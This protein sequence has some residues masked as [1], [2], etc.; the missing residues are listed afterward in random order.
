MKVLCLGNNTSDTDI[1]T[2]KLANEDASK[3]HGLLSEL[4]API[5]KI[6]QNGWYH[7]SVYDVAY[8]RLVELASGFDSV[9]MLDQPKEQYSHPDAFYKTISLIESLPN[10]KFLN[11]GYANGIVFFKN[12]VK[13]NKSFCIF[14]FIELLTNQR[15]DGYTT[16]C[17]RSMTPVAHLSEITD[18]KTNTNYKEIRDKMINGVLVPEHCS[19]C[20]RLEDKNILSAR[21][22]E[23]VEWANR[24][25]LTSLEDLVKLTHPTYYEI[26]PGNVCNL[27]CRM[28]G[29]TSSHLL[30]REYKK[31][32]LISEISPKERSNFSIIDFTNLKK[33]YV[34]GGEPT[35]MPEFYE[36]L[37]RCIQQKQTDFEFLI[38][39][40]A[41]KFNNRLKK[42]LK[43]FSNLQ[44]IV[45]VDGLESLNHY[46][47]W[48]SQWDKI[49]ENMHYLRKNNCIGGVNITISIY[50]VIGLFDLL[51][52]FDRE[53]P[54]MLVHLGHCDS[55]SGML[56]PFNFPNIKL[57]L[58]RLIPI[59]NLNCYRNNRLLKSFVDGI[60]AHYQT[61]RDPNLEKLKS[62]F[63]FNDKLDRSRNI[64][65]VD[66]I[67]ELEKTRALI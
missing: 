5:D 3:C 24:L 43:H 45:S 49:V 32:N 6:T 18:W 2:R 26:R 56:S 53:F 10:G 47:R 17:C 7:S 12:L 22:Q 61:N 41:T 67:P 13:I 21:Q 1:K 29:P 58:E 52:F 14:P 60:I 19:T 50:N 63:E 57:A 9:I 30:G 64:Q 15:N 40:N 27:Q 51:E 39:T 16:V 23:T 62:F 36:F 20:Y 4:N 59:Q 35:A 25:N 8:G 33:L 48:P 34:S 44:F 31:L 54:G 42:Q 66:Y 46:I 11:T 38:N 55:K 28:C 37:D 65:L